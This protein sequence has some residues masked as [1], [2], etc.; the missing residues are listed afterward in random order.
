MI[1]YNLFFFF[2]QK[3]FHFLIATLIASSCFSLATTFNGV[4]TWLTTTLRVVTSHSRKCEYREGGDFKFFSFGQSSGCFVRLKG[5]DVARNIGNLFHD[6][7]C[8]H[9]RYILSVRVA[10]S[11]SSFLLLLLLP[12]VLTYVRVHRQ[13]YVK[14]WDREGFIIF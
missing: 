7:V 11:L 12:S 8:V 13:V 14:K 6:T 4:G 9:I 3:S 10:G 1:F 5:N 2:N